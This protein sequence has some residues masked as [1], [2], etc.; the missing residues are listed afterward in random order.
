MHSEFMCGKCCQDS[1][2]NRE[3]TVVKSGQVLPLWLLIFSKCSLRCGTR[4]KMWALSEERIQYSVA[5]KLARQADV[6]LESLY[7]KNLQNVICVGNSTSV[8][9]PG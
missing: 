7:K 1:K 6:I 2:N 5:M 9:F 3:N 8:T 4:P